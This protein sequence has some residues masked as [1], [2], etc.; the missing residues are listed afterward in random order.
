[1]KLMKGY[2]QATFRAKI[3]EIMGF[4]VRHAT[5]IEPGLIKQGIIAAFVE[6]A[7]KDKSEKVRRKAMAALG[8]LLFYGATQVDEGAAEWDISLNLIHTLQKILKNVQED[9]VV[10]LYCCK[11]I[12]N[13]TAQ[14]KD[15]GTKFAQIETLMTLLTCFNSSKN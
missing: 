10:R 8:E 14:A 11:S 6:G 9:E 7:T 4:L 3:F 5:V 12:E 15:V 13:I 1:M 2:K